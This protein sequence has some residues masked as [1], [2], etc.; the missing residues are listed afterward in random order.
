MFEVCVCGVCLVTL[1]FRSDWHLFVR[2]PAR[3]DALLLQEA[4]HT[5]VECLSQA[6]PAPDKDR[7]RH[8]GGGADEVGDAEGE[9][10]TS[11]AVPD[12][13]VGLE[14]ERGGSGGREAARRPA[15]MVWDEG[16]DV[17]AGT[18]ADKEAPCISKRPLV[19]HLSYALSYFH[20]F[21]PLSLTCTH[22]QK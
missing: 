10:N 6:R 9:A 7:A 8:G 3:Q 4:E 22:T 16:V 20:S 21:F 2:R 14:G 19:S 18:D 12:E 5:L 17:H 1:T 15:V 11:T 13:E